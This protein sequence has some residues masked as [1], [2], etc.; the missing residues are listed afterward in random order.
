MRVYIAKKGQE[1]FTGRL[2]D[3]GENPGVLTLRVRELS[4]KL[5]HRMES[6]IRGFLQ[7]QSKAVQ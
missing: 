7:A 4:E 5:Q 6:H 3:V 1:K 2:Y